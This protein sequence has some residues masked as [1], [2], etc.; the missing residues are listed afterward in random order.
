VEDNPR[1]AG[2]PTRAEQ[3]AHWEHESGRA[4]ANLGFWKTLCAIKIVSCTRSL[5]RTICANHLGGRESLLV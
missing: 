3:L 5:P 1:L 2:Y 4:A